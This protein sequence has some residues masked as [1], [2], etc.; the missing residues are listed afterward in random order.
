MLI[1]DKISE[2]YSF[3]PPEHIEQPLI[4]TIVDELRGHGH[5]PSTGI[6]GART[7]LVMDRILKEQ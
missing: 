1:T 5:C 3:T 4:Q 7:S 2:Q 6:S